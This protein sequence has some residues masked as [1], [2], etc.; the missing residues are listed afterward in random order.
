MAGIR[1]AREYEKFKNGIPLSRKQAILGQCYVCNGMEESATDCLGSKS[2]PLYEY[3]PYRNKTKV[4]KQLSAEQ[5][6]KLVDTLSKGRSKSKI[7]KRGS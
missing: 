6:Q 7:L 5:R 1:G 4:K 3:S 2:C